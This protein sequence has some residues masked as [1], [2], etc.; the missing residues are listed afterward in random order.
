LPKNT[1]GWI[2]FAARVGYVDQIGSTIRPHK[3]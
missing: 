1:P 3:L 2:A